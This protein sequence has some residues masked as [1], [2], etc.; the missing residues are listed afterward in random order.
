MEVCNTR[1]YLTFTIRPILVYEI[2]CGP[3]VF[4]FLQWK[5]FLSGRSTQLAALAL[6]ILTNLLLVPKHRYKLL[7]LL[8]VYQKF[9][10]IWWYATHPYL[11]FA[12]KPILRRSGGFRI[13]AMVSSRRR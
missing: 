8:N 10:A 11:A 6:Y 3:L 7:V 1:P 4:A 2:Y 13:F 12:I 9:L 5:Q